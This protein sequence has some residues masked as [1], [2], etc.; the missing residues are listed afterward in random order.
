MLPWA[1]A[2]AV[3]AIAV[4]AVVVHFALAYDFT[5][6]F[7]QGPWES[8]SR[9]SSALVSNYPFRLWRR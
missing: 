8:L 6:S 5:S 4:A 1:A 3:L 2:L 9:P 7:T